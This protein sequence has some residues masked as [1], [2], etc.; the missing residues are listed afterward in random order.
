MPIMLN[1]DNIKNQKIC[2]ELNLNFLFKGSKTMLSDLRNFITRNFGFGDFIFRLPDD[3]EVGKARNISEL[4][5]FIET[6]PDES[7]LFHAN[8]NHFS[9]LAARTEFDLASRLRP[10]DNKYYK[11]GV[12][13]RDLLIKYLQ[14]NGPNRNKD[15]L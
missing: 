12:E 8:S 1:S 15:L 4:A 9:W 3:T 5:Q 11:N 7:L 14:N 6:V 10:I 2:D 13:L